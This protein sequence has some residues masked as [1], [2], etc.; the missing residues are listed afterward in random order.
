M[1]AILYFA[2]HRAFEAPEVSPC[3]TSHVKWPLLRTF[4]RKL[5]LESP[6]TFHLTMCLD[7]NRWFRL[8]L[9]ARCFVG[10]FVHVCTSVGAWWCIRALGEGGG[11]RRAAV[12]RILP[13]NHNGCTLTPR[14]FT[15][16]QSNVGYP[17][18]F[19]HCGCIGNDWNP[20]VHA[21]PGL[22]GALVVSIPTKGVLSKNLQKYLF[23]LRI[24]I[25]RINAINIRITRA[26]VG[27]MC[28]YISSSLHFILYFDAEFRSWIWVG[29]VFCNPSPTFWKLASRKPW[30]LV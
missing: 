5:R 15:H 4:P 13:C 23:G 22:I 9:A 24:R 6:H 2:A 29:L 28:G 1:H 16:A 26:S 27:Q 12:A 25:F 10:L 21:P 19:R 20:L 7:L 3:I 8:F 30:K 17:N 18:S 14:V 11:D